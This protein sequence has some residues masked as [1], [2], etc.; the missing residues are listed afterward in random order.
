MYAHDTFPEFTNFGP[1]PSK[2][3]LKNY[4]AYIQNGVLSSMTIYTK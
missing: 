2:N 4:N 1:Y 3:D